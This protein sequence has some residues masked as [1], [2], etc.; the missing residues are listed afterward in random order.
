MLPQ[1]AKISLFFFHGLHVSHVYPR[2]LECVSCVY[3]KNKKCVARASVDT[4]Y[5][6]VWGVL[7]IWILGPQ[8]GWLTLERVY[9]G[10]MDPEERAGGASDARLA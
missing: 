7:S 10:Q 9:Y 8:G 4:L 2:V 1:M 5:L 6:Q 3:P